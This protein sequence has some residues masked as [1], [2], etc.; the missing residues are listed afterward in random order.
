MKRCLSMLLAVLLTVSALA[1]C[2][3]QDAL[4]GQSHAAPQSS[5]PAVSQPAAP[6]HEASRPSV[7]HSASAAYEKLAAYKTGDYQSQSLADFNAMLAPTPDELTTFLAAQAEVTS[8]VSP[9]DENY[10]FFTT[11]LSFSS[12]ELYCE[13]RGEALTFFISLAKHSRPGGY[14]DDSGEMVYDFNCF[15]EATLTYSVIHPE[16]VTFAERDAA[17]LTIREELQ[18]YLNGCSEAEITDGNIR[19]MLTEKSAELA[20]RLSTE[21]LKLSP[22]EIYML[23]ISG[24]G[25]K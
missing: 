4:S 9:D 1:G 10:E 13:H 11:T 16:L 25:Q 18:N 14:L 3:G 15:V 2:A 20:D 7:S 22:C 5:G 24:I 8:T 6:V 23:D 12:H 17:L 19:N 21:H